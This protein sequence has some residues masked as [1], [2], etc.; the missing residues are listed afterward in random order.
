MKTITIEM[1][2]EGMITMSMDGGEPMPMESAEAT[3]EMLEEV[4]MSDSGMEDGMASEQDQVKEAMAAE[5]ADEEAG[6]NQG[7]KQVRGM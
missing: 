4:L 1:D 6:F 2:D 7:F 3:C 5:K